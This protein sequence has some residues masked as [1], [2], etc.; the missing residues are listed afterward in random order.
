MSIVNRHASSNLTYLTVNLSLRAWFQTSDFEFR[1]A[2]FR[3]RT[4]GLGNTSNLESRSSIDIHDWTL[5]N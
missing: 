1:I 3:L 5:P 2:D 4:W